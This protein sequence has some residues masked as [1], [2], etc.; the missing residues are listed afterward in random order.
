MQVLKVLYDIAS[1]VRL[2]YL[3]LHI[4]HDEFPPVEASPTKVEQLQKMSQEI[5]CNYLK[6]RL[7]ELI[8][9]IYYEG[10]LI[11][12]T[13]QSIKTNEQIL[14]QIASE[15]IDWDFYKKLEK[16]NHSKGWFH[17][18]YLV[19]KQEDDSSLA[20]KYD[21]IT[22]HIRPELHLKLKEQSASIND[23]VSVWTPASTIERQQYI[24]AGEGEIDDN[25]WKD[26]SN[27]VLLAYFNFDPEAAIILMDY[28]TKKL[29]NISLPFVFKV[30]HNPL[31]YHRCDS[32]TLQF[33]KSNYQLVRQILQTIFSEIESHFQPQVPIF[34]K[35]IGPGIGLAEHPYSQLLFTYG[36]TFGINRCQIVA[37]TL[38]D[39][40]MNGDE[41]PEMRMKYIFQHFDNLGIDLDHPYLNPNSEDI[42]TPLD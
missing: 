33:H 32:G 31:N 19:L 14:R 25:V 27:P 12:Q 26:P 29:N 42:Y 30:L 36:E 18:D 10:S 41:S 28:L 34:T 38:V 24:A 23:L 4:S 16:N 21:G 5:Q 2:D 37:N 6:L 7:M 8:Y 1:H 15:E 17:S 22:V 40:Y 20:V 11:K 3:T 35:L 13:S 39:A 9:R